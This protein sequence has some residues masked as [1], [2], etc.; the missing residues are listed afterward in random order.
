MASSNLSPSQFGTL[1][2]FDKANQEH[3]LAL[4]H[5]MREDRDDNYQFHPVTKRG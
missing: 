4:A 5:M 3:D 2:E 1:A